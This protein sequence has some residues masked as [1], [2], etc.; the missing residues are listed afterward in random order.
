MD[1]LSGS[2]SVLIMST[3]FVRSTNIVIES[4]FRVLEYIAVDRWRLAYVRA[5]REVKYPRSRDHESTLSGNCA[6]STIYKRLTHCWIARHRE[7]YESGEGRVKNV[8]VVGETV[9]RGEFQRDDSA[10]Y[11]TWAR[12]LGTCGA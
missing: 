11:I 9:A 10:A 2:K 8:D 7:I 12:P 3:I 6:L 5:S 4:A 1:G